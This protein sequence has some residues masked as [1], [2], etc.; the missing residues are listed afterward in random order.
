M[1]V[2]SEMD[3]VSNS[4][5]PSLLICKTHKIVKENHALS[6]KH[7]GDNGK[8][9]GNS[10]VNCDMV[11]QRRAAE[12]MQRRNGGRA[13]QRKSLKYNVGMKYI[14][15][16]GRDAI[17]R[18]MMMWRDRISDRVC[19]RYGP[20][21]LRARSTVK[22]TSGDNKTVGQ[23]RDK[24]G[25]M[26]VQPRG[27]MT[28]RW[29]P[30]DQTADSDIAA[31]PESNNNARWIAVSR[32]YAGMRGRQCMESLAQGELLPTAERWCD[33]YQAVFK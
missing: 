15:G 27:M 22:N 1:F 11:K 29:R 31:H 7:N 2:A 6:G 4:H 30:S 3:A 9:N 32:P 14:N 24:L 13:G 33:G 8:V 21:D 18:G 19:R 26:F 10:C 12:K 25:L 17:T 23:G 16:G 20:F 28:I 5:F